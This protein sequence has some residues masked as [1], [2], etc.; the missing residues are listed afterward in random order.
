MKPVLIADDRSH[1]HLAWLE[2]GGF[3][4][5]NVVYA[6]TAPEVMENYNTLTLVD[7]LNAAFNSVF[8][9]STVILSL[10]SALATWAVVPLVGLAVYHVVTSEETLAT[11]RSRAAI[12]MALAVEVAL[13]FVLPPRI[14]MDITWP[15][16]RWV[17]PVITATV[18]AV[19][20]V[21][22]VRRREDMHLFGAFFL[23]TVMN[24]LLQIILYLLL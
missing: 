13:T 10:I 1:L 12:I 18:T 5:Y 4:E 22:I 23:F 8:R 6:S 16:L 14:G 17:L 20:T 11:M 21:S 24:S 15:V 3:G 7:A 9:F 19:V 2:T